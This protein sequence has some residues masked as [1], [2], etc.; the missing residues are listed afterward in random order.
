LILIACD[1]IAAKEVGNFDILF[2]CCCCVSASTAAGAA[3]CAGSMQQTH[4]LRQ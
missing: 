1:V 2:Y 4:G 3:P